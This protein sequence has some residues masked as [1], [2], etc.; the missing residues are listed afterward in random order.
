[1]T[2]IEHLEVVVKMQAD[3]HSNWLPNDAGHGSTFAL[4]AVTVFFRARVQ[5]QVSSD[6]YCHLCGQNSKG[7]FNSA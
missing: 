1:M 7:A 2:L 5:L 4:S 6:F 3:V